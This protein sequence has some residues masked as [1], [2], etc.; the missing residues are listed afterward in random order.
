MAWE[1]PLDAI[2]AEWYGKYKKTNIFHKNN[3][4]TVFFF[5]LN[6]NTIIFLQW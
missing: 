2:M 3:A 6:L 5:F 1:N 4:E